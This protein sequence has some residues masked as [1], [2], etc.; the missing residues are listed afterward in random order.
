MVH[1]LKSVGVMSVAKIMG[2]LY[3]CLGL[4]FVPI[5]LLIGLAGSI[6]GQ[7]KAMPFA[8][9]FGIFFA[10]LMPVVYGVTGFIFGALFAFLYNLAAKWMGGI[11]IEVESRPSSP[12]AP[13][14]VVPPGTT[15]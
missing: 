3:A 12:Y 6:A 15:T 11:E 14:P 10:L 1:I 7:E 8:G 4:L 9:I 2:L 5:F 13:Y